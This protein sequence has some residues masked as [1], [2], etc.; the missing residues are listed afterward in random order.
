MPDHFAALLMDLA[1]GEHSPGVILLP[2]QTPIG[3]AIQWLPEIWEAS[4]HEEWRDLPTRL[5]L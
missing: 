3:T 4:R 2:Q 5:P 1:P